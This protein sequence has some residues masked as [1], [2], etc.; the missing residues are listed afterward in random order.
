MLLFVCLA[1]SDRYHH[2]EIASDEEDYDDEQYHF[3]FTNFGT[4]THRYSMLEKELTTS[5]KKDSIAST[6]SE[7]KE[8]EDSLT[9]GY[10]LTFQNMASIFNIILG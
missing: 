5:E 7:Q 1:R 2:D 6:H 8:L 10:H 9:Y 3:P 4:V